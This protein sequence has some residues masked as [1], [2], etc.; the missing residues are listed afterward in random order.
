MAARMRVMMASAPLLGRRGTR[1]PM[2]R[3][4]NDLHAIACPSSSTCLAVGEGGT[5][6]AST[7][8]GRT[9][10]SVSNPVSGTN[11]WLYG[12]ACPSRSACLAVGLAGTILARANGK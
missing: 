7:D 1:D 3:P 6:L 2:P 9:W 4:S 5:I 10:Y 12:I 11:K 8:G